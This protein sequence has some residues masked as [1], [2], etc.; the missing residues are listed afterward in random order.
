MLPI[1]LSNI[2][3]SNFLPINCIWREVL[4]KTSFEKSFYL[5]SHKTKHNIQTLLRW[6]CHCGNCAR[7]LHKS[8]LLIVQSKNFRV[9]QQPI[10]C[11]CLD[12]IEIFVFTIVDFRLLWDIGTMLIRATNNTW[13]FKLLSC[14]IYT[15]YYKS[16]QLQYF[17]SEF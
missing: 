14:K 10:F 1:L 11:L 12:F 3:I 8:N 6:H 13:Y 4:K 16:M 7:Q 17:C 2:G 9:C 15:L 5:L